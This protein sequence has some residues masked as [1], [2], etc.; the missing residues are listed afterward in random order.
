MS[1]ESLREALGGILQ[2][3]KIPADIKKLLPKDAG[4]SNTTMER[5]PSGDAWEYS[6]EIPAKKISK[7]GEVGVLSQD[8]FKEAVNRL[9]KAGFVP[10]G[11]PHKQLSGDRYNFFF[12]A[13]TT[14][15]NKATGKTA[16]VF[17][18]YQTSGG[19]VRANEI[20]I[21]VY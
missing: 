6:G 10:S 16:E 20:T 5:S 4:P 11:K 8:A 2:E 9:K 21:S 7:T 19:E 3:S 14:L 15:T 1:L 12:K 17:V 13:R 18:E